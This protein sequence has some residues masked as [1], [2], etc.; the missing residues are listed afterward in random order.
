MSKLLCFGKF[1]LL[2]RQKN[3]VL[4][5]IKKSSS[6]PKT[7]FFVKNILYNLCGR[8]LGDLQKEKNLLRILGSRQ[9]KEPDPATF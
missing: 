3:R 5:L 9:F 7:P 2:K 1:L 4:R 6:R 8:K